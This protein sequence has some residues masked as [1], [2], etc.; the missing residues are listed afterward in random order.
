MS[1]E[2]SIIPH[3]NTDFSYPIECEILSVDLSR[4]RGHTGA[5]FHLGTLVRQLR[6]SR[7]QTIVELA[8]RARLNKNTWSRFERTGERFEDDTLARIAAALELTPADL[9]AL[10]SEQRVRL[11]TAVVSQLDDHKAVAPAPEPRYAP[12]SSPRAELDSEGGTEMADGPEWLELRTCFDRL[13]SDAR[14]ELL[15]HAH[16]LAAEAHRK[17]NQ[18][19]YEARQRKKTA[20]R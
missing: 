7:K 18:G 12:P 8:K 2:S 5:V 9:Y 15:R 1:N 16:S 14:S 13:S 4:Q 20:R 10:E 17:H 6:K 19:G 3:G 11:R